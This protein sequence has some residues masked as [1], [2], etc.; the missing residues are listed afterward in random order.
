LPWRQDLAIAEEVRHAL[1]QGHPL[2]LAPAAAPD[3]AADAKFLRRVDDHL[4]AE[5]QTGLV[6]HLDPV[7]FHAVFDPPP[8]QPP[9]EFMFAEVGDHLAREIA[10]QLAPQE[11]HHLPSAE[12]AGAV[13]QQARG[14][15]LELREAL[16]HQVGGV[17]GLGGD[18]VVLPGVEQISQEGIDPVGVALEGL[19]PVPEDQ[20]I[21]KG[22]RAREVLDPEKDVVELGVAEG[23]TRELMG[24][25]FMAVEVEL[26]LQR[27]PGLQLD[28][29]QPELAVHEEVVEEQALAL[30]RLDVGGLI[31]AQGVGAAGFEHRIDADQAVLDAIARGELAGQ[32]FHL[33]VLGEVLE[34]AAGLL[35]HP[36]RVSLEASRLLEQEAF[37][38]VPRDLLSF[39]KAGHGRPAEEG[40]VATEDDPVKAG[41]RARDLVGVLGDELFHGGDDTPLPPTRQ[42][43]DCL[44]LGPAGARGGG[45]SDP[46]RGAP[47][48]SPSDH[49]SLAATRAASCLVGRAGLPSRPPL[50]CGHQAA[51]GN[52]K[53][54]ARGPGA[55]LHLVPA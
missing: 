54:L 38:L 55:N 41:Q 24:E 27:E 16:E 3:P 36:P 26:D 17:L 10:A 45:K 4:D 12:V 13:L 18:P 46:C 9:P 25:P 43:L 34:G 50:G 29:D 23:V 47:R 52:P 1:P 42:V 14:K 39:Q 49:V 22:L 5:D 32:G 8:R 6:I 30:G 20:A 15:V 7:L 40:Q 21:R 51:V 44:A 48:R 2:G 53:A 28:V 11:G 19:H 31:P 35:G 37:E 33:G